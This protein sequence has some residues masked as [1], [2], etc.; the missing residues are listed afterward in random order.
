MTNTWKII[1]ID[2]GQKGAI[3]LLGD[4]G[5]LY[6]VETMPH[7]IAAIREVIFR[8]GNV[9]LC[10]LEKQQAFPGQGVC[11]MFSFGV[12]YGAL[13]GILT[14]LGIPYQLVRPQEWKA[15]VLKG[16]QWKGDKMVSVEYVRRKYPT[17][18]LPKAK[19]KM[20]GFAD[21]LCLAEYGVRR[22]QEP[23]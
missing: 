15:V 12:H 7:S 13:Q 1:G 10:V 3:A 19:D 2:P 21:A 5:K 23:F 9:R 11:S 20:T 16:L 14:C 4:Y 22:Q 8:E 6:V 18:E 17:L